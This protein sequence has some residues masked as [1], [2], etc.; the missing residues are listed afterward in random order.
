MAA[1]SCSSPFSDIPLNSWPEDSHR[2]LQAAAEGASH[3]ERGEGS[4]SESSEKDN[5]GLRCL[6][7]VMLMSCSKRWYTRLQV[8]LWLEVRVDE[9]TVYKIRAAPIRATSAPCLHRCRPR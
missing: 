9:H 3:S 6:T 1:S 2:A 4:G 5:N 7:S 8:Q